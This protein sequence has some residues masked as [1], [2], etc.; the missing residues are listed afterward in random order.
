[1]DKTKINYKDLF[2]EYRKEQMQQ[3]G[4]WVAGPISIIL[5]LQSILTDFKLYPNLVDSTWVYLRIGIIPL[6]LFAMYLFKLKKYKISPDLIVGSIAIYIAS[7]HA[8][9]LSKTGYVDSKYFHSYIQILLGIAI[10]P[11][12]QR[13]FLLI[14]CGVLGIYIVAILNGGQSIGFLLSGDAMFLKTYVIMTFLLF[15]SIRHARVSSYKSKVELQSE[16][17][18]RQQEIDRL[19][20]N[21]MMVKEAEYKIN[22]SKQVAHDIRSPLSALTMIL[23]STF[24]IPED[25]RLII[26]NATQ[27]INDIAN[28]LLSSTK[29]TSISQSQLNIDTTNS[30]ELLSGI[31]DVLVSEKRIQYRD[32]LRINIEADLQNSYGI[33][34]K[35]NALELKRVLSN[36]VN[37]SVESFTNE[38]GNILISI[39]ESIEDKS[40]VKLIV[41]DNGSG[42]PDQIL[43]RLGQMGVSHGKDGIN[44]GS[45]LGI[46]HAKNTIES[47]GGKFDIETQIGRGTK[48]IMTFDRAKIPSWFVDKLVFKPDTPIVCLDDDF[49][50]HQIWAKR[51]EDLKSQGWVGSLIN[52]SS[53]DALVNW[54]KQNRNISNEAL[55]LIDFEFLGQQVTGLDLVEQ[56]GLQNQSILVTSRF[57]EPKI[58][59]R[60]AELGVKLIPKGMASLVFIE[61]ENSKTLYDQCLIDDDPLVRLTWEFAAKD[62]GVSIQ[63]FDSFDSFCDSALNISKETPISVDVNL[64]NGVRGTD[65]ALKLH[66]MGF[67]RIYLA[68]GYEAEGI[69]H[70]PTC[71]VAVRGKDPVFSRAS[72]K[73]NTQFSDL[74]VQV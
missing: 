47:F 54:I 1:M 30:V 70:V 24:E 18:N 40:K 67:K 9:L 12:R 63:T 64:A 51:F 10:L 45:G 6:S 58:Q 69:E 26:R 57:E 4:F 49:S 19:V 41:S 61:I 72:N 23:G 35:I 7:F 37:N 65:V 28:Q 39:S 25:R 14:V 8:Y 34:A 21:Q 66:K 13:N 5:V 46:Y 59:S 33:F 32:R 15:Y 3:L 56:F 73:N 44:S 43:N 11:L 17:E 50:I 62:S 55:Y 27:R 71:V 20:S 38:S 36:L 16:L 48:I 31:V 22:I 68:T 52:L 2:E 29:S 42:I 60:C 53:G 74:E